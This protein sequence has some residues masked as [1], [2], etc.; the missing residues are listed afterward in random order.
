MPRYYIDSSDGNFSHVDHEGVELAGD[1]AARYLALDAL[2][3]MVREVLPDGDQRE[4]AV[5]VR[6]EGGRVIYSA[7]LTLTGA[8]RPTGESDGEDGPALAS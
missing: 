5:C 6:D 4:F 8:W 3:D 1:E 7:S 2:P